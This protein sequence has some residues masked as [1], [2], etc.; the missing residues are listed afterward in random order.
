MGRSRLEIRGEAGSKVGSRAGRPEMNRGER[1]D[2]NGSGWPDFEPD[3]RVV[4]A[5]RVLPWIAVAALLGVFQALSV[6][7]RDITRN[8]H[9]TAAKATA[10][11]LSELEKDAPALEPV[12]LEWNA[13][14][15][16]EGVDS[17][18]PEA[19]DKLSRSIRNL[20]GKNVVLRGYM[21]QG[22]AERGIS[23][24]L[25]DSNDRT[26]AFG[27]AA[28][29][30]EFVTVYLGDG[31]TTRF[32]DRPVEVGGRFSIEPD[33]FADE[34]VDELIGI[35]VLRDARIIR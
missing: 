25:L 35:F 33:V 6:G 18:K 15:F 32:T 8:S 34:G 30:D 27:P 2:S 7:L 1:S 24:F 3:H 14:Q 31:A 4:R 19:V 10:H 28:P 9:D 23:V 17:S 26:G 13:L 20:E 11:R 12:R 29:I 5:V 21:H 22:L 16:R